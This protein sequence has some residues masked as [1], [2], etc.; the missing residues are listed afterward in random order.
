MAAIRAGTEEQ[1]PRQAP[2]SRATNGC[3][4][5]E[6]KSQNWTNPITHHRTPATWRTL[7]TV[8]DSPVR[9]AHNAGVTN[10]DTH[11]SRTESRTEASC[12]WTTCRITRMTR[13]IAD[14]E[15]GG[16]IQELPRSAFIP[17]SDGWRNGRRLNYICSIS[18]VAACAHSISCSTLPPLTP[19]PPMIAPSALSGNP[20]PKMMIRP[21]S[22]LWIPNSGFSG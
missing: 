10:T 1:G 16:A 2:S 13:R 3:T 5:E 12:M 21:P 14:S 20:P 19:I 15:A 9:V 7:A 11:G 4:S 8:L 18:L 22:A 6:A 17:S